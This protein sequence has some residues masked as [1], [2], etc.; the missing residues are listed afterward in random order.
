[1][2]FASSAILAAPLF[3]VLINGKPL[4]TKS[5][6]ALAQSIN[7]TSTITIIHNRMFDPEV[8]IAAP[9][10]EPVV[11]PNASSPTDP[12]PG[13]VID[14]S[15]PSGPGGIQD[16]EQHPAPVVQPQNPPESPDT[17]TPNT[18][19]PGTPNPRP[20][21]VV[22][23]SGPP[24][25]SLNLD[26]PQIQPRPRVG[27]LSTVADIPN[28]EKI[29][30]CIARTLEGP[31]NSFGHGND[32][33]GNPALAAPP[34]LATPQ[35]PNA[36]IANTGTVIGAANVLIIIVLA[37]F[38]IE[39]AVKQFPIFSLQSSLSSVAATA[40]LAPTKR[41]GTWTFLSCF[42]WQC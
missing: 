37:G 41:N 31:G 11:V 10:P 24:S 3:A 29:L 21:Q 38:A 17:G 16:P 33:G 15:N 8:P 6:P 32:N 14:P 30:E 23:V 36:G 25:L 27:S 7:P 42:G 19:D 1:M 2:K 12:E 13:I 40:K 28:L 39:V 20:V 34:E 5:S 4:T 22:P 18:G 26:F 9:E 35:A